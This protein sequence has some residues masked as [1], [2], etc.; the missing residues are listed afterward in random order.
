MQCR[1][2]KLEIDGLPLFYYRIVKELP[3]DP[4]RLAGAPRSLPNLA[5]DS[6]QD[7]VSRG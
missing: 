4:A 6:R 2:A 7:P 3:I 1:T 5:A